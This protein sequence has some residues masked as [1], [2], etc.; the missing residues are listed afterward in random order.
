[1]T[2]C[3][4]INFQLSIMSKWPAKHIITKVS[5]KISIRKTHVYIDIRW[6]WVWNQYSYLGVWYDDRTKIIVFPSFQVATRLNSQNT[7]ETEIINE[8]L[9]INFIWILVFPIGIIEVSTTRKWCFWHSFS[10]LHDYWPTSTWNSLVHTSGG[11][12]EPC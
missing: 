2:R 10:S 1:M 5:F 4:T 11:E 7:N 3:P 12:M 8:L 9:H 6:H